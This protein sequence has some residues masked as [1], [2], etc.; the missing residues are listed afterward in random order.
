MSTKTL[1]E[2]RMKALE[3][4]KGRLVREWSPYIGAVEKALKE[5]YGRDMTAVDKQ[6]VAQCLENSLIESAGRSKIFETTT[7]D[8]ISFLGIQLPVIAALLPSLVLNELATVQALD[9]RNGSI[10][11]MDLQYGQAK[12]GV[13]A[14]T[15]MLNAKTGHNQTLAGRRY[16]STLVEAE[17]VTSPASFQLAYVPYVA[18]S[19]TL[20]GKTAGGD[21]FTASAGTTGTLTFSESGLAG[22]VSAGGLIEITGS[23][24]S[25]LASYQ[26]NYEKAT[27]GVPEVNFVLTGES[28]TALDFPLR[29][30][31]TLG[32][33]IDLEKAH[34][35]NLEDEMIKYLGGEIKFEL[36][37]YGIDMMYAAA[38]GANAA[39][40]MAQWDGSVGDGQEWVWKKFQF[41]DTIESGNNNIFAKT[42]RAWGTHIVC[43]NNVARVIKQLT[44][45]FK[46]AAGIEAQ[47]PTGPIKIGTLSGRPVIQDPLL[48]TNEFFMMYKGD[49]ILKSS[50]IYAPYIPLFATNT[51]VTADLKAQKGFLSSSGFKIVNEAMFCPGS[52]TGLS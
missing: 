19:L 28:V 30:N 15:S 35:L 46:P 39:T 13:A 29:T 48:P 23:P 9:R 38:N 52:I 26:Y 31:Y 7:A 6:N 12:G 37:H 36:D 45:H 42:L 22:T 18:G 51:L 17:S 10:F 50:F 47:S 25:V 40:A 21:A 43:G 2:S 33:A 16:A 34:G 5:K 14:N 27:S 4:S 11:F 49:S 32:A 8:N 3:E 41:L 24:T 20:T 1:I 44:D